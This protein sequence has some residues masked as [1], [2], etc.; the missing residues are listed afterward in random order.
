M[1]NLKLIEKKK[2]FILNALFYGIILVL[3][4]AGWKFLLPPLIPFIIAFAVAALIQIPVR[5]I[6]VTGRKKRFVSILF[7]VLFYSALFILAVFAGTRL[8]E[9]GL[10]L[11]EAAPAIYNNEIVPAIEAVSDWMENAM[12]SANAELAHNIEEVVQQFT[13]NLGSTIS[14]ISLQIVQS[15]STGAVGIPGMVIRV[16]VTIVSTVFLAADYDGILGFIKSVLPGKQVQ[17]VSR[18]KEYMK[19]ILLIYLRSYTLLFLLTFFELS[20]GL[21]ILG[22]PY[23]ILIGL[24]IAV[25]DILPVLGTGGILIPWA[26]ILFILKNTGLAVGILVLYLFISVVRNMLEPKLVGKQIGL[27]PLAT[28]IAMFVGLQIFGVAGMIA[29]PLGLTLLVEIKLKNR[30]REESTEPEKE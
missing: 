13:Q 21:S 14:E 26:V 22:I 4:W 18:G 29:F 23:P 20:V 12:T 5:K 3:I 7:C 30:N 9:G 2:K 15:V 6:G 16:I 8:L 19:R 17:R 28:L 25:F 1:D 11:V 27:H 10:K 24:G